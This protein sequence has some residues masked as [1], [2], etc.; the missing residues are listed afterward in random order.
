MR[1]YYFFLEWALAKIVGANEY[2]QSDKVVITH[3]DTKMK[4]LY[5]EL[6]LAYMNREAVNRAKLECIDPATNSMFLPLNQLYLGIKV[7]SELQKPEIIARK[8]EVQDFLYRCQQ[9]LIIIC[10]EMRIRYDFSGNNLFSKIAWLNPDLATSNSQTRPNSI[11]LLL[12]SVPRIIESDNLNLMQAIDDQWRKLSLENVFKEWITNSE[13]K[14]VIPVDSFWYKIRE[15]ETLEGKKDFKELGQFSLDILSLPH[16]SA[17]CERIFS[18]INNVKTKSRN[19]LYS[20]TLQSLISSAEYISET[21]CDKF[22]PTEK[23]LSY[24]NA[25]NIYGPKNISQKGL[26]MTIGAK[27]TSSLDEIDSEECEIIFD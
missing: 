10:Q 2:F 26:P 1:M 21:G 14:S 19:R 8:E 27:T 3:V 4:S 25:S 23:M 5:T 24:M 13:S 7:M 12:K 16:S 11:A 22:Q 17:A 6:L 15:V 20:S 18:K 9:F